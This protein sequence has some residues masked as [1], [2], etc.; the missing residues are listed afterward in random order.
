MQDVVPG[1][2]TGSALLWAV[3]RQEPFGVDPSEPSLRGEVGLSALEALVVG[4]ALGVRHPFAFNLMLPSS[5]SATSYESA[6]E[7]S[8]HVPI[9]ATAGGQVFHVPASVQLRARRACS[10][11][12]GAGRTALSAPS[13]LA[14][15]RL[16]VARPQPSCVA[17]WRML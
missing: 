1:L 5:L 6:P 14:I 2:P 10:G 8:Q 9:L 16:T 12:A 17:I 15:R 3:V 7:T 4:A 13:W 11:A